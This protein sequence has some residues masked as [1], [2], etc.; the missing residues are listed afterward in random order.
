M[1]A[2]HLMEPLEVVGHNIQ[3]PHLM[4]HLEVFIT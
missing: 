2:P 3:V 1:V 4:E